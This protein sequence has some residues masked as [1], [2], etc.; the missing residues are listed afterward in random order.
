MDRSDNFF[1]QFCNI[2]NDLLRTILKYK[3]MKPRDK[4][5]AA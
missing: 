5:L 2:F 3:V 4:F 1:D